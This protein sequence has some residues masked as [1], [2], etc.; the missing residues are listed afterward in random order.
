M[1]RSLLQNAKVV[2]SLSLQPCPNC[3]QRLMPT[4]LNS[5]PVRTAVVM[6]RLN[7][8]P[9]HKS[10]KQARLKTRHFIYKVS[11]S[12][13]DNYLV[14]AKAILIQNV[15]HTG[16]A[17]DVL[18][19]NQS[20]FYHKLFPMGQAV[21]ATE[22]NL[23]LYDDLIKKRGLNAKKAKE[24][25]QLVIIRAEQT[26]N[27]LTGMR[28][29][30][31]LSKATDT[32]LTPTHVMVALWKA[33]IEATESSITM[34]EEPVTG[35]EEFTLS[36]RINDEYTAPFTGVIYRVSKDSDHLI[37][38]EFDGFLKRTSETK[39]GADVKTDESADKC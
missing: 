23:E 1:F 36:L 6:E 26:V 35:K 22:A 10:T 29:P 15:R 30:I 17:G 9:L 2:N 7:P 5:Q 13:K 25:Q 19:L 27:D 20:L 39:K 31:A 11:N 14:K 18:Y 3:L 33:G 4:S 24:K 28:L 21:F 12:R 16:R 34:P 37:P 8:L 32:E 38:S